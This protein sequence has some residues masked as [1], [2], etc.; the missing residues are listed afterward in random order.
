[1]VMPLRMERLPL[2]KLKSC[3]PQLQVDWDA[4]GLWNETQIEEKVQK[5]STMPT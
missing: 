4:H 3:K 1:M 2:V 5:I